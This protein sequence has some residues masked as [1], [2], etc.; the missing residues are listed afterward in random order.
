MAMVINT[1]TASLTTQRH[2]SAS[3][4]DMEV[5]MERMSSGSRVNS[6][7]DDAAGLAIGNRMT[8]QV[9]G[10]N[11][12]VR[13]A[14]DG[15]SLAQTAEGA[16]QSSSNI[17]QR[18]RVLAVQAANDT[19]SAMDRKALNNE[20]VQLKEELNRGVNQAEF[21]GKK[22]L[23][24]TNAS[25]T[26]QVGHKSGDNVVVNL[27]NMKGSEIGT[28]SWDTKTQVKEG[29]PATATMTIS[30]NAIKANDTITMTAGSATLAH[31]F[32]AT[33]DLATSAAAYVAKWNTNAA[34]DA[35]VALYTASNVAGAIT[36]TEKTATTGALTVAGSVTAVGTSTAVPATATMTISGNAIKA[37]DTMTMAAGSATYAH[38][39]AATADLATSAA[40]Y[41]AA[42]NNN[43][44]ANMSLYTAS[45]AAGTITLTE[46][47]AT[48]GD[49]TATGSVAQLGT[50]SA[51]KAEATLTFT[52]KAGVNDVTTVTVGAASFTHDFGATA[53]TDV[54]ATA[55]AFANAW[56]NSSNVDVAAYTATSSSGV[57]TFEQDTAST[58]D[59]TASVVNSAAGAAVR[60]TIDAG[61]RVWLQ[62]LPYSHSCIN[63]W[64]IGKLRLLI[65]YRL[66]LAMQ[67]LRILPLLLNCLASPAGTV[68]TL[69]LC[70]SVE[71]R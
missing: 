24:G 48:T 66:L 20:I 13:N 65:Q 53:M 63:Y 6:S 33:A 16:L 27:G 55:L 60:S 15:I 67:S 57:V 39:F 52:T 54:T 8:S 43:A 61:L 36:I 7:M 58:G 50:S 32:A 37:N 2:L 45:S 23:N 3:R 31:T 71:R 26:F 19:Y 34:A 29:V 59:L 5:A 47:T 40:A 42:W 10:L 9:E 51:V 44:D 35:N 38:T 56:N 4:N 68:T 14:N 49:L 25:F 11:Q 46:D 69:H 22:I 18:I 28:Q 62:W 30:G 21:N 1:N 70:C 12:A 17:L 64:D 41:V